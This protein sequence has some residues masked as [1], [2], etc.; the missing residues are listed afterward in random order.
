MENLQNPEGKNKLVGEERRK[1]RK[2]AVEGDSEREKERERDKERES[3]VICG[4]PEH[5]SRP[6]LAV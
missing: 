2:T 5:T 1:R 6:R 4:K 3:L